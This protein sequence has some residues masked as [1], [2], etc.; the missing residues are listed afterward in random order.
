MSNDAPRLRA[1]L[2]AALRPEM[3]GSGGEAGPH[4]R[5]EEL[6]AYRGG[7]LAAGD[8]ERVQAHLVACRECLDRLLDLDELAAA[9]HRRAAGVARLD[10]AAA[11]R[12]LAP[13]LAQTQDGAPAGSPRWRPGPRAVAAALIAATLALGVWGL[14]QRAALGDLRREVERLSQPQPDVPII[15]LFPPSSPRGG[16]PRPAP[17]ELGAEAGY[18]TVVL[19]LPP[20][21]EAAALEAVIAD[22]GGRE[23]WSGRLR[24]S[25]HGT[26]TLGIPRRY[27]VGRETAG[28]LRILLYGLEGGR[29]R[30]LETYALPLASDGDPF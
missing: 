10:T 8:A 16:G 26:L 13:R 24:G 23:I 4:P 29:R 15:D 20:S 2:A 1:E 7:E 6:T 21:A 11:W 3:E 17:P 25:E 18:L 5:A 30:R 27:L 22:A 19:H 28:E 14:R 12:A 9:P